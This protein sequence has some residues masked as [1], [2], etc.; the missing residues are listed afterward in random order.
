MLDDVAVDEGGAAVLGWPFIIQLPTIDYI[1]VLI[2]KL[3][4]LSQKHMPVIRL[5]GI[6][7]Y[8][9]KVGDLA[10]S[11]PLS[12]LPLKD[13]LHYTVVRKHSSLS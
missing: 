13:T 7:E 2:R 4:L 10:V 5:N 3:S 11:I 8:T 6:S 1:I 12:Q 9:G